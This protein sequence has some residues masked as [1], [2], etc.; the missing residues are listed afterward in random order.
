V[1]DVIIDAD[2]VEA[3]IKDYE[4]IELDVRTINLDDKNKGWRAN[5]PAISDKKVRLQLD[6]TINQDD[7]R[8]HPKI[9]C[10]VTA[11]I[12]NMGNAN[13]KVKVVMLRRIKQY[14]DR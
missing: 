1:P 14:V 5:I 2:E 12:E 13:A 4:D 7:L 6:P 9:I 10:D 8:L 11:V 3:T